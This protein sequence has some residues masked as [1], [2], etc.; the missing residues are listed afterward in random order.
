MP[1]PADVTRVRLVFDLKRASAV[2]DTAVMGFHVH[3]NHVTGNPTDWPAD[4]NE[5]ATKVYEKWVTN[6]IG[7]SH[8]TTGV[9]LNRVE[10]YHL[11]ATT[12]KTADKGVQPTDGG[13][14]WSGTSNN[15][16]LPWEVACAVSIYGY[17]PGSFTL[18]ARQKRGRFY[19][20]PFQ[21]G[22][23]ATGSGSGEFEV[24][25]MADVQRDMLAFLNDV[26]GMTVGGTVTP[27]SVS[28]GILSRIGGGAFYPAT[29]V[30]T[31]FR[32][33]SQRRRGKKLPESYQD[34]SIAA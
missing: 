32:P 16:A 11:D 9:A 12:G 25:T 22:A 20:P 28:V 15:A 21:T 2:A 19:L 8:W 29:T 10:A 34:G 14:S 33:D 6:V 27:D 23:M 1:I 18:N 13:H 30:R 5:I 17:T 24:A 4:V 3:R 7:V 26:H 31:G